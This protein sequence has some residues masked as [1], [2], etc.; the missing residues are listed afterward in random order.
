MNSFISGWRS[1]R[2]I[3][4]D[5]RGD[6]GL[7]HGCEFPQEKEETCKEW[8]EKRPD[9]EKFCQALFIISIALELIAI[10][11]VGLS[12]IACCFHKKFMHVLPF[13]SLLLTLSLAGGL[14]IFFAD[15]QK[16]ASLIKD[17][18]KF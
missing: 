7:F 5:E 6:V 3:G 8:N 15:Y 13:W 2:V 17:N 18:R 4:T 9:W 16:D 1:F 14:A 12:Y 10:G 11:W